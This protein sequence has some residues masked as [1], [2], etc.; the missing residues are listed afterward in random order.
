MIIHEQTPIHTKTSSR[1]FFKKRGAFLLFLFCA[2]FGFLW[3]STP[4]TSPPIQTHFKQAHDLYYIT[5]SQAGATLTL[6][7]DNILF[8]EPIQSLAPKIV[9]LLTTQPTAQT[10]DELVFALNRF[11]YPYYITDILPAGERL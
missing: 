11:L 1:S 4:N 3:V 9:H 5:V 10:K 7:T 6:E 2:F 8:V